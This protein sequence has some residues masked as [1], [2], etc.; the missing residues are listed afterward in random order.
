MLTSV[1]SSVPSRSLCAN[2]PF[3]E[4]TFS[5]Y[6][7]LMEFS[8]ARESESAKIFQSKPTS[9]FWHYHSKTYCDLTFNFFFN[10][11]LKIHYLFH[12]WIAPRVTCFTPALLIFLKF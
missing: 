11:F 3:G 10:V 4:E 12:F 9:F 5:F 2:L 8:A 6:G 1:R 7:L